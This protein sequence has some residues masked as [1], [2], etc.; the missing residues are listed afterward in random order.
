MA[1]FEPRCVA[2][3]GDLVGEG[4][5]W[6]AHEHAMYWTD[7]NR[8]LIHQFDIES[9]HSR[10]WFFDEP[11]VAL[12]LSSDKGRWLVA[13]ASRLVWWWPATDCRVDHGFALP[14]Y[15]FVRLNDGRADA[16]G[17]FWV[18]SMRNN[19]L[20][21]GEMGEAGGSD[22]KMHRIK[23]DGT[24]TEHIAGIGISNTVCWSP[25]GNTFYTADTL[26]NVLWAYDFNPVDASLGQ[27]R[28]VLADFERGLPDG[29]TVDAQGFL[30][31]CRFFGG[32]IV[33]IAP[34]GHIDR[35]IEMPV[36]NITTA[37]FGGPDL[38]TLYV[39]SASVLKHATDRLAG[40]LWAIDCATPGLPE[41]SVLVQAP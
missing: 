1:L 37:T 33:R 17:N 18:G 4:A 25:Q 7:I 23:P 6:S 14:G 15:P 19:V 12:S 39:T 35:L 40:S 24:V 29:S 3:T 20:P 8:F 38:R 10:S 30:W 2:P 28:T 22:G 26:A 32:C 27:R 13:L 36:K 11:V 34:D 5:V 21:N 16:L 41:H 9:A 31:N